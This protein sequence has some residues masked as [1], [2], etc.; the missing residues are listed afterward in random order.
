STVFFHSSCD[1]AE[2][3]IAAQRS[4]VRTNELHM[5]GRLTTDPWVLSNFSFFATVLLQRSRVWMEQ[6]RT[7]FNHST[8]TAIRAPSDRCR[9]RSLC[10]VRCR[11]G[12]GP[13]RSRGTRPSA[14]CSVAD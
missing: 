2:Y 9:S 13:D 6:V 12:F 1:S 8:W 5:N 10:L 14:G 4:T 7:K 11:K 3:T